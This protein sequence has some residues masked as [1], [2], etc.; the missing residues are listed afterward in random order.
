MKYF[1][2]LVIL[3]GLFLICSCSPKGDKLKGNM[4]D[5]QYSWLLVETK[6][7]VP[8]CAMVVDRSID[9]QVAKVGLSLCPDGN[10]RYLS[11]NLELRNSKVLVIT[12]NDSGEII[13]NYI[14]LE[15]F[16]S[17]INN[18][19]SLINCANIRNAALYIKG[20]S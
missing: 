18:N 2:P 3:A 19:D 15:K 12:N 4:I 7:G 6:S 11:E 8:I 5:G 20:Q 16:N 9:K 1:K 17:L 10:V 13:T 14:D